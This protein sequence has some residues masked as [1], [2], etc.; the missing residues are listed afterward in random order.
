MASLRLR[1]LLRLSSLPLG[2]RSFATEKA[3][4]SAAQQRVSMVGA[5]MHM[6]EFHGG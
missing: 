3:M 5:V 2:A 1:S 4:G 6:N